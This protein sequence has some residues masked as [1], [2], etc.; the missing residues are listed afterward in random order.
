VALYALAEEAGG[1]LIDLLLICLLVKREVEGVVFL[2]GLVHPISLSWLRVLCVWVAQDNNLA[3]RISILQIS[4][5]LP[6][7]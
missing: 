2:L 3:P 1:L 5:Y 4:L 6:S 7:F